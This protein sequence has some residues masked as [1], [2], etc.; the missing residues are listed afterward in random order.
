[1][2]FWEGIKMA[3]A[4]IKSNKMRSFLTALGIIFGVGA[5]IAMVSVAQGASR[6][7]TA[8]IESMGSNM[9]TVMSNRG[10]GI[11]L[12]ME[13]AEELLERVPTITEA[14]P[15]VNLNA[16]VK[17]E[18]NT[19]DAA[20]EGVG[21]GYPQVR[22]LNTGSGRFFTA[23]EIANR[24]PVAL[25]GETVI[26]EL[27][28]GKSPLGEK[29]NIKG[30]YFTVIGVLESKGSSM[31]QDNDDTI[32]IPVT[33]A[34]RL[35]LTTDVNT[36]YLKAKSGEEADLAVAHVTSIYYQKYKRENMV[37]VMSQDEMLSTINSTTQTFALML[38]AIAGIS[39]LV[40]G[41]GIMNIMLVSVTE[42]TREIGIR[43]ALGAKSSDILQQ[44]LVESIFLSVG[45]GVIGIAAG[46]GVSL[47]ISILGG[48]TT[49]VSPASV[50]ISFTFAFAVGLFF[51][52]YPAYKA[53]KLDPIVALRHE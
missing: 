38:G 20:I 44:F 3:W 10:S 27:F 1:M 24:T 11:S 51:G 28:E 34:Q 40:G 47:L 18:T 26:T 22:N 12:K 7:I 30:Q 23:D 39:L 35:S 13:E 33:L 29:I 2:N 50:L 41:I 21:E 49:A 52:G 17:W 36:I 19:Y 46:I 8:Q 5:V 37:R 9:I 43:K 25:I 4:S 48:W 32:L 15:V 42:I 53:A 31:G 6:D 45:G 16:T 14:V